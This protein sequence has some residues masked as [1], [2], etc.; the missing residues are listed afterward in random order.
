MIN[1]HRR[2]MKYSTI[3]ANL[4]GGLGNQLFIYATAR[5][6][7]YRSNG[8][9]I[10]DPS[11][12]HYDHIYNR[13][14]ILNNFNVRYD[15]LLQHVNKTIYE[16]NRIRYKLFEWGLFRSNNYLTDKNPEDSLR[17]LYYWKGGKVRLNGYWQSEDF[18][19]D[20]SSEIVK[21]LTVINGNF[22][23]KTD[24]AQK[25]L[26]TT[27]SVFLH[28]R[29]YR[30][31]PGKQDGSFALPMIYFENAIK[32][33]QY[34]I[35]NPHFFL[36]SDDHDW[37]STKLK[38]PKNIEIS[39]INNNNTASSSEIYDFYLMTICQ[40]GIVANS[41]YS[42][43]SGWLCEQRNANEGKQSLIFCPP[44]TN[45]PIFYPIRWKKI[46]LL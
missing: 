9:L 43:W 18:F 11:A 42:W 10:L 24:I 5:A 29:S 13:K 7:A 21:D 41:S 6:L 16:L 31:V 40:H 44:N 1:V 27:N 25:I 12:L 17:K 22:L 28:I 20:F 3:T 14:L 15:T 37:V 39:I 2:Y 8:K 35:P 26:A 19:K 23:K 34:L 45:N 4:K 33:A 30:E 46:E 32:A 36:F 38:L